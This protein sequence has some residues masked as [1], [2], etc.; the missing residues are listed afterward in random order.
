[1]TSS[2]PDVLAGV[3]EQDRKSIV[4]K[5]DD[6]TAP[7]FVATMRG[8]VNMVEFLAR[9]CHAN[10]EELSRCKIRNEYKNSFNVVET[11]HL[12][13]P[14]WCAAVTNKLEVVELL[15]DLGAD[16]NAASDTGNTPVLYAC[17]M[18]NVDVVKYLILHGADVKTP[19]SDGE[20]CLMIAIHH[21]I[22]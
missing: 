9:E 16:I 2:E 19:D 12:V 14:L 6:R 1:M 8:N 17:K 11:A 20:T 21:V 15:I 22:V 10:L 7:L 18:M 3:D 4:A 13:T 5:R